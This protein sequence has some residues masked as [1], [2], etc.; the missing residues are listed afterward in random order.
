MVRDAARLLYDAVG[1]GEHRPDITDP[2]FKAKAEE[3]RARLKALGTAL[4]PYYEAA[5]NARDDVR[6]DAIDDILSRLDLL[7][8]AIAQSIV[9]Y[10]DDAP[11]VAA[12]CAK[13]DAVNDAL[14]AAAEHAEQSAADLDKVTGIL[15]GL[16][17]LVG[18]VAGA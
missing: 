15:G 1:R 12:A 16:T 8:I 18:F 4:Y 7:R 14:T 3:V 9:D 10:L 5:Q 11:D 6:A 13:I 17:R 2:D